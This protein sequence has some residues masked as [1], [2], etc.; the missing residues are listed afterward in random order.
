MKLSGADFDK[1]YMRDMVQDHK[2]DVEAFRVESKSGRDP[3]VRNFATT[4]LPTL[5]D[6]MKNA[7]SIEPKVLP[8]PRSSGTR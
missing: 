8:G 6:H 5:R 1:A 3:D 2:K 4:T 7:E